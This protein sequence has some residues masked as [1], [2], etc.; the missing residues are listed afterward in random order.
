[1][2]LLNHIPRWIR[3][4]YF[5]AAI[6]FIVWMGFFDRNDV[7]LQWRR[8]TELKKLQ[9]S[10]KIMNKE[11]SGTK[12]DQQELIKSSPATLERYAR[13]KYM[14]KKDNEDLFIITTNPLTIK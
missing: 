14:M 4:K 11:I 8:I 6:A 9:Q 7:T 5:I 1:M 13:E 10:E 3:S 2:K 12:Y